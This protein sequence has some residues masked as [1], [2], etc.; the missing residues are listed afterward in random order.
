LDDL[1]EK[2]QE[3]WIMNPV[4]VELLNDVEK[5]N[6]SRQSAA[7]QL[8]S[9]AQDVHSGQL[10]PLKR[11][12]N[13]LAILPIRGGQRRKEW[14]PAPRQ[15]LTPREREVLALMVEG[16]NNPQIGDRLSISVTA[17]RSYVRNVLSK[18][19]VSNRTEAITL[20]LHDRLET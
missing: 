5:H 6:R 17:V 19:G 3:E 1:T 9:Q 13:R 10:N 14:T 16:L 18:S 20:V 8:Q 15:D 4:T 7:L 12:L 2:G 11:L